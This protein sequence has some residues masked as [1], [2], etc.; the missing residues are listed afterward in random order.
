MGT[1]TIKELDPPDENDLKQLIE[2]QQIYDLKIDLE[3]AKHK[4]EIIENTEQL[5]KEIID[6][7][8][9]NISDFPII[10][11]QTPNNYNTSQE[12]IPLCEKDKWYMIKC[13]LDKLEQIIYREIKIKIKIKKKIIGRPKKMEI[14]TT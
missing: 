11:P 6:A 4:D 12:R 9:K 8:K 7:N 1:F 5:I 14:I 13:S 2:Y 3:L 10:P